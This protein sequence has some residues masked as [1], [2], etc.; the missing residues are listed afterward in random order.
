[1]NDTTMFHRWGVWGMRAL[2]LVLMIWGAALLWVGGQVALAGGAWTY[3]ITGA[4]M[5][6]G[7][8][9]Q[10]SGRLRAG[11]ALL[12]LALLVTL[13]WSVF[14]IAAKG[15]MPAWGMDLAGRAGLLTLIV[16]L[17]V[18]LLLVGMASPFRAGWARPLGFG[19]MAVGVAVVAGIV[20]LLWERPASS[21]GTATA[22]ED[23]GGAAQADWT[24]YGGSPLGQ[25]YTEAGLIS[26][27]N[28]SGLT[29]V[30]RFRTKD[31]PPSDKVS[32]SAQNTPV[33]ADGRLFVCSPSNHVFALDP[34]SG[35]LLWGYD[36]E[37]PE[38]AM[39]PLF[40]VACR[41]VGFHDPDTGLGADAASDEGMPAA[42]VTAQSCGAKVL[43][44]TVDG[45]LTALSAADGAICEDFGD[46]GTVDLTEGMGMQVSGFAS[47]SSGP[48]VLGDTIVIGQQVSDNQQRD[49]PSGVVRAYDANTGDLLWAWDA[50]RQGIAQEPL[51]EGEVYPRGT[52]NIWNVI[53]GDP[54]AGLVYVGTGNSAND[55]Y[56]G[57]RTPEEDRFT[58]AI[59]AIDMQTGETVWDFSTMSHDLW[60][61]DV[62]AQPAVMD[63]EIEGE[64]R[65]VVVAAVKTGSI[66]IL[67]AATGE[68]LRPVENKPAP[69][70]NGPLPGDRLSETQ[71]YSTY[72]P[73]FA[74]MP[75]DGMQER[76]TAAHTWG[77]GMIDEAM[78]RRDFL[79]MDYDGT[80]TPP[81][82]NPGGVLLFPGAIGGLNWG[83]IGLDTER[84][85]LVTNNS[86]LAN[87][88][89]MYPREEVDALPIGEGGLHYAQ[90]IVPHWKSPWGITRPTWLSALGMPCIAPPWGM[91]NAT[92]LATGELLWSKPLG[93]GYDSGPMG[94]PSRVKVPLGTANLGG[95]LMTSSGLTFIAAAQDNFLRAYGT[96]SGQLLW[97]GRLPAGGQSSPM[98]YVH[99]GRQYVVQGAAGHSMLKTEIGDYVIGYALETK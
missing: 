43:V 26:P 4:L 11:A 15:F 9:V 45:R 2:A 68:P 49:A 19:A 90:E 29:E 85:I 10:L 84:Q 16:G 86:R 61:Y 32:Y 53:S 70:G 64:T 95:P 38:K 1:M 89:T 60:D 66:F 92:D 56:G 71:P 78:C 25:G 83:G 14:E 12:V 91:I 98:S 35:D 24:H 96:E 57:T 99:E 63:M 51:E 55:H 69:Q 65:R 88:L 58:A 54:E 34:A 30:W 5:L 36:P 33:Y 6:L 80:Y 41:T 40:S 97:Q 73:N 17:D 67:D 82:D 37:V 3:A 72:Y 62:G 20:A 94:M 21:S 18:V 75:T 81:S 48:T 39:E 13:G 59:V 7:G 22:S 76:L 93:T 23:T 47:N 31:L 74:G 79:K 42:D 8:L 44:S 28:V 87:H 77:I 52:P 50:L 46:G 27:A